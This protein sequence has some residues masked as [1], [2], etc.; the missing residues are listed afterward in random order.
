MVVS[1]RQ[2]KKRYARNSG[3]SNYDLMGTYD[4]AYKLEPMVG[5]GKIG[6]ET[7]PLEEKLY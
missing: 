3:S 6:G 1:K 7:K 4:P 5:L 2:F